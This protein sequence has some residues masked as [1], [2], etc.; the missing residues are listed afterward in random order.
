MLAFIVYIH[1]RSKRSGSVLSERLHLSGIRNIPDLLMLHLSRHTQ[2]CCS[3]CLQL[4]AALSL[5]TMFPAC[6]CC[7]PGQWMGTQGVLVI[8]LAVVYGYHSLVL[9]FGTSHCLS[10]VLGE[11]ITHRIVCTVQRKVLLHILI[12]CT[13]MF[14]SVISDEELQALAVRHLCSR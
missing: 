6:N 9:L 12:G 7:S 11:V 3:S 13:T 4:A 14:A 5:C 1:H 10:I 2:H 8:F